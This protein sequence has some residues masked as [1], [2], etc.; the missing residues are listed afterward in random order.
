MQE[1]LLKLERLTAYNLTDPAFLVFGRKAVP[2]V[3]DVSLA[4]AAGET[5]ALLGESGSGKS[6]LLRAAAGMQKRESGRIWLQ[7]AEMIRPGRD[8]RICLVAQD[9]RQSLELDRPFA[10]AVAAELAAAGADQGG[11]ARERLAELIAAMGL[12]ADLLDR[13]PGTCSGG[14]LQRLALARALALQPRVLLLDEP[15]SGVDPHTADLVI[16]TIRACQAETG[17]AVL[18]ATHDLRLVRRMAQRAAVLLAGRLVEQGTVPRMLEQPG[19][20]HV[21]QLLGLE[22]ERPASDPDLAGEHFP[23]CP[24]V[25]RCALEEARCRQEFPAMQPLADGH[26]AAC[27]ALG[28]AGKHGDGRGRAP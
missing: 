12:G 21:R 6:T 13:A 14:Q 3:R 7:G 22:E 27:H 17:M 18:L 28:A 8:R 24:F 16:R 10:A 11:A 25:G 15:V 5:L 20:P 26:Q 1:P 4:V 23:G 9:P 2:A 19:H